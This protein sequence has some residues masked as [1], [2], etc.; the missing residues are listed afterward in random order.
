MAQ[1]HDKVALISGASRGIGEAIARLFVDRG[2][3]VVI[4]DV[5]DDEGAALADELGDAAAF[6]HLDV[7]DPRSWKHARDLAVERF[8]RLTS[9]VNNAGI[10]RT[11]LIEAM[12]LEDYLAVVQ[13]N[14]VG[15]FLGMQAVIPALRDAASSSGAA[16]ANISSIAGNVGV[17]GV[18]A[19]VASKFAIRGMTKSAALELGP[20]GIRV[21]SVHPGSIE[22]PLI[23]NPE[24]DD[25]D[26]QAAFA[27]LPIP[28]VGRP[29]EVAELVSFLVSDA[30]SYSTGGEFFIDGGQLAGQLREIR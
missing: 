8:G 13:V 21:N 29:E 7:T 5:L 11:G 6:A 16:I 10:V 14:Q 2:A 4:G 23:S 28:R 22:T 17:S 27:V 3:R 30:S 25:V 1:L 12:P 9:L 19:Y 20:S 15:T 24:F 26:K 18:S